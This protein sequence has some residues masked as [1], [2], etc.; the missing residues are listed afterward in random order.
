[1]AVRTRALPAARPQVAELFS[2]AGR[3]TQRVGD[4][5]WHRLG[6]E[7][8]PV[9]SWPQLRLIARRLRPLRLDECDDNS[10]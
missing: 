5:C 7:L 10:R 4:Q 8:A 6:S 2:A 3:P 9:F 1:M